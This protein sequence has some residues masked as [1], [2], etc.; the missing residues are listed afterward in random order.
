[1]P[2]VRQNL[3]RSGAV[4]LI[5]NGYLTLI[6]PL[7]LLSRR[8]YK[9]PAN[10][11]EHSFTE[12]LKW[13]CKHPDPNVDHRKWVDK[14]RSKQAVSASFAVPTTYDYVRYPADI[15][16]GKLP[17]TYV[18]KAAHGWNMN[19]L[20]RNRVIEGQIHNKT[21]AGQPANTPNL[22]R[23]AAMWL[24]S[25]RFDLHK[26]REVQYRFPEPGIL[27]EEYV[28][29]DYQLEMFLFNG[30]CRITTVLIP[31]SDFTVAGNPTFRLYDQ[32]WNL[33]EPTP[34]SND[35]MYDRSSQYFPPPTAEFLASVKE[36]FGDFDH[37]RA[38]FIVS[39]GRHYFGE[40]TFTHNAGKP[41]LLGHYEDELGQYWL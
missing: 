2:S 10:W 39:R 18:M 23:I 33:L 11:R 16:T 13:R 21:E 40:L 8:F 15:D 27:I 31:P 20:V 19:L 5:L 22:R 28:P 14:Y 6:H 34:N 17:Q 12:K 37:V 35:R 24:G 32:D 26:I 4:H 29:V 36:L 25:A 7:H 3:Q 1:M 30:D 41:S 38:D 9:K